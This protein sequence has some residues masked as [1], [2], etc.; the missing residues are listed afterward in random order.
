MRDDLSLEP[1]HAVYCAN[2]H[3]GYV[4]NIFISFFL[5]FWI[6]NACLIK[7]NFLSWKQSVLVGNDGLDASI[8][9]GYAK[10][11]MIQPMYIK[12]GGVEDFMPCLSGWAWHDTLFWD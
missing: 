1:A 5:S 12:G 11:R 3:L 7:A 10:V 6:L 9:R 8:H 4:I 2:G